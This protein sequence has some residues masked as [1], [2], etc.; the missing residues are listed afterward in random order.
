MIDN[1]SFLLFIGKP[2]FDNDTRRKKIRNQFSN[3]KKVTYLWGLGGNGGIRSMMTRRGGGG[4][5]GKGLVI[6]L[7]AS[8]AG[9]CGGRSRIMS[10]GGVAG[11]GGRWRITIGGAGGN[12]GL[13]TLKKKKK[14]ETI[15]LF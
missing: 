3:W 8:W 7:G 9:G 6:N 1:T 4:G 11:R 13:R 14:K 5:G 10:G 2:T 12:A 15:L